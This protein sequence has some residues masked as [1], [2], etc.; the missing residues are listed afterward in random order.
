MV[1]PEPDPDTAPPTDATAEGSLLGG[2]YR[3]LRV[4][5]S[6][7][8]G[9]VWEARNTWTQRRVAVKVLARSGVTGGRATMPPD[10][11]ER[12][13]REARATA[14]VRHP[15]VV[16]VLDMGRDPERAETFIVYEFL[17][18]ETLRSLLERR[19]R[20]EP[21]ELIRCL[22]PAMEAVCAA[23]AE[24]VVHRDLKPE[25]VLLV[26]EADGAVS[27]R[28]IDFGIAQ[29]EEPDEPGLTLTGAPLGTPRY[30]SPEQCRGARDVDERTD[31]W[32]MGVIW[33]EALA[34]S[35][36]YQGTSYNELIAQVLTSDAPKLAAIRAD[37]PRHLTAAI[38]H[39]LSRDRDARH[40]TMR[41]FIAAIR[42]DVGAATVPSPRSSRGARGA[43]AVVVALA[44]ALVA[45]LVSARPPEHAART[46]ALA[47]PRPA[48][49]AIAAALTPPTAPAPETPPPPATAPSAPALR[50]PTK[51]TRRTTVAAARQ[52]TPTPTVSAPATRPAV[53]GAPIVEP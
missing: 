13:L 50:P 28:V 8:M 46:V 42:D 48:T 26:A 2:K 6:G 40:P 35:H 17:D 10:V 4:V 44:L 37:L 11:A 9:V 22:L 20:L 3:L 51:V 25:N 39:A 49:G 34:G 33:F 45:M 7:G 30:M 21:D 43:V 24:G 14:R 23:H 15:H 36:P 5:G 19:G 27:P 47:A 31:V 41:A 12:F 29:L 53:N 38:D 1:H 18:G 52:P 32:S 16:D